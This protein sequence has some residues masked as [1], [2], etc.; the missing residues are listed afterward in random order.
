[1]DGRRSSST[2]RITLAHHLALDLAH[3]FLLLDLPCDLPQSLA[4]HL[5][6]DLASPYDGMWGK[7]EI[8]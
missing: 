6:H 2:I 3:E 1:M 8:I 5:P 7:A 4:R